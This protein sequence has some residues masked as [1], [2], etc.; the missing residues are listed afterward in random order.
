MPLK[1][2]SVSRWYLE[3]FGKD[4]WLTFFVY[5]RRCSS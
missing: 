5:V 2:R 3:G 1:L 4:F